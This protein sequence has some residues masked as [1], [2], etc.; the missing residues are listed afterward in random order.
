MRYSPL[1]GADGNQHF[2]GF[3]FHVVQCGIERPESFLAML[4]FYGQPDCLKAQSRKNVW[5]SS[6]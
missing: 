4:P 5:I 3:P 1:G 2:P 6:R